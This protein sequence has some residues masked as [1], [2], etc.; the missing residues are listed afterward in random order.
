MGVFVLLQV[1]MFLVNGISSFSKYPFSDVDRGEILPLIRRNLKRN[2]ELLKAQVD[3]REIDFYNH[4][5]VDDLQ[6]E[7]SKVS[8]ILAA[9]GKEAT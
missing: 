9:D 8:I 1:S 4:S 5:T 7:C 6:D 2:E 3:V